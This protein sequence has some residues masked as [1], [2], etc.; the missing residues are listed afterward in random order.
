MNRPSAREDT[1]RTRGG[2]QRTLLAWMAAVVG[3][4]LSA[5]PA[6]AALASFPIPAQDASLLIQASDGNFYG[7]SGPMGSA[8]VFKVSPDGAFATVHSFDCLTEGCRTTAFS[9]FSD[10]AA[11]LLQARDGN[12]YGTNSGGGV[13]DGGTVFRMSIGGV[14]TTLHSFDCAREGCRPD[15]ALIRGSDGDLY[16]TTPDGG[17]HNGGTV[18]KIT[19]AGALTT[20]HSFDCLTEG[21]APHGGVI[22]ASDGHLYGTTQL[23]AVDGLGG[24]VLDLPAGTV[25]KIT[26]GGALTTLYSLGCSSFEGC[27]PAVGLIE[28]GDGALYGTTWGTIFKITKAGVFTTVHSFD[29]ATQGCFPEALLQ[30]RDSDLYGLTTFGA[31]HAAG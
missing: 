25:F 22:Q 6:T 1:S 13:H 18:F 3:V 27:F 17:A 14:V 16:G 28:G 23:G 21:C 26:T 24:H 10:G 2:A 19:T 12:F 15:A 29:C 31:L 4:V 20:L 9:V 5:G 30:A 7:T 8:S 11:G